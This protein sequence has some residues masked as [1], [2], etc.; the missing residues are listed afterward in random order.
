MKKISIIL[1]ISL[2]I[3]IGFS[4]TV[5]A[6]NN[7]ACLELSSKSVILVE[8]S[9][10]TVLY[11]KDADMVLKPAS[12][13]KVMTLLLI[14]EAIKQGK[15]TMDDIV[16]ISEHAASMGGSQCFF[17]EGEEQRVEDMI[18]CIEIA[19]GN[20]AAV[21]MAEYV[22]GS[23]EQFV[24]MMNEKAKELGMVN[25]HFENACGLDSENH[26]TTARDISIMSRELITK[27][28]QIY[29]YSKIWMDSIVHE[30]R[31]GSSTFDLVNTNKFLNTYTGATGLK[32]GYTSDAKYCMSATACRDNINLIAVIMCADTKEIR[33]SEAKKLLD[34][35]FSCCEYYE[36]SSV[37]EEP[38]KIEL[39]GGIKK[40][41]DY[42]T[43]DELSF[44]ICNKD[45]ENLVKEYDIYDIKAPV[46]K[47][48]VLG[49]INYR[50]EDEIV[51]STDICAN[52]NVDA[53]NTYKLMINILNKLFL[54]N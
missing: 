45:K 7:Q 48:D 26:V 24:V 30:T 11:E 5:K 9:S 14:F 51:Y 47:G 41:I 42:T 3:C 33:N 37:I 34:Y 29:D 25:T 43:L 6:K 28:P 12:V 46:K 16:T 49:K 2:V 36:D 50:I 40:Y 31:R 22:A 18:K 53:V 38:L 44:V 52:E 1:M 8:A 4:G 35:G 20:D 23:E 10:G 27:Y 19:S 39:S 15:F 32:T 54:I 21:A 13:T 17:E